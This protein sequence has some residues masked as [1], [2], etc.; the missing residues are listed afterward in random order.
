MSSQKLGRAA[1]WTSI[2]CKKVFLTL[3]M[4]IKSMSLSYKK[5][6]SLLAMKGVLDIERNSS[7]KRDS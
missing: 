2:I 4:K 3:I 5:F 1:C 6:V 7:R